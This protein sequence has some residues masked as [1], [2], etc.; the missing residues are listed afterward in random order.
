M[1]DKSLLNYIDFRVH[2]VK[3]IRN[4]YGY[5][6]ELLYEDGK[7]REQQFS[8]FGSKRDAENDRNIK[9]A[10]LHNGTY[11][12][13]R[14]I[15]VKDILNEWM[16]DD[17]KKRARSYETHYNY[18]CV[19][20]KHI[21]PMIGERKLMTITPAVLQHMLDDITI[22]SPSVANQA[23][24]I[25]VGAMRYAVKIRALRASPAEGLRVSVSGKRNP[26]HGR[27]IDEKR[28]L[29]L[30]QIQMLI[31]VAAG[32]KIYLMLLFNVLMGL[33][34][35]EIIGLKYSDIDHVKRTI[36]IE[37][38]LGRVAN[39]N[40]ADFAP[41]T[42]TK[43]EIPTK[44]R[45]SVRV[46]PIPDIVYTAILDERKR[47]EKNRSRR[48]NSFQDMDYICCSS[49]GRPRCSTYH[50]PHYKR[51]LKECG[52]PDIRWHDL[53]STYCTLLLKN[54]FSPKAVSG[55]MGHAKEIITVDVYGDNQGLI[56]DGVPELEEFI[57]EVI[58]D[59]QEE[60]INDQSDVILNVT[61]YM[62][63]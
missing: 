47:Y 29:S 56:A 31:D 51:L 11:Q 54:N 58:P 35:S 23:K 38:Q 30:E 25:L 57:K 24:V 20:R 4:K 53:R 15:T 27:T 14:N 33:R 63:D 44:T 59:E 52:L 8:G 49:Y 10:E 28:T 45:S 18:S 2:K 34:R 61:E 7:K 50:V 26:Y 40:K 46:L 9:I 13:F 12:L 43:Q 17:V 6:V 19:I 16:T 36:R 41:N 21:V 5:V 1:L 48:Q 62:D 37:R 39:S 60:G 42:F 3:H 55:L 22:K 32:T